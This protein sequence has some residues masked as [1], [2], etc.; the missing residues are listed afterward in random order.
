M[1]I[2]V[3]GFDKLTENESNVYKWKKSEYR[4][5]I[6]VFLKSFRKLDFIINKYMVKPTSL[7]KDL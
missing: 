2:E 4:F 1:C 7:N 3:C 5:A 6:N